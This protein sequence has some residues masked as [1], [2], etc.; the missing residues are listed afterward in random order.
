MSIEA[1]NEHIQLKKEL[2]KYRLS[3]KDIHRLVNLL[4]AA[5]KYRYSPSKIVAKLRN[6]KRLEK[7]E[8][9]MKSSCQV[10]SKKEA[11]YKD[12]IPFT[13][14]II[15]LGIGMHGIIA[16]E[17][18]IKEAAKLYNLSFSNSTLRL[19]YDMK[20][21]NKINGLKREL[22]RLSLQKY[23][24]DQACSRQSQSLVNLAK[25]K[26]YGITDERILHHHAA[27]NYYSE[28]YRD[29]VVG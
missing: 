15:S 8:N 23:A 18:R 6:I 27:P 21:Y 13:E 4:L 10:L 28:M 14:E 20:A 1:I 9:R 12:V 25:L 26:S 24:L 5:K 11:R 2:K 16:L 3:T 29:T 19:I 7:K 22:E 17:V